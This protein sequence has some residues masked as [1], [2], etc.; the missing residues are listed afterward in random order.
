MWTTDVAQKLDEADTVTM[1]FFNYETENLL[2][3][4]LYL[5][6]KRHLNLCSLA[7]RF[8][9]RTISSHSRTSED[10]V[11]SGNLTTCHGKFHHHVRGYLPL[12][13]L[14]P[15][16]TH[17][18]P[19][20]DQGAAAKNP[21]NDPINTFPAFSTVLS[22]LKNQMVKKKHENQWQHAAPP[23]SQKEKPACDP[24]KPLCTA[25]ATV[26]P[27]RIFGFKS[28]KKKVM[29]TREKTFLAI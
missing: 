13:P 11:P 18:L 25:K 8:R 27:V 28:F 6:W 23:F 22:D 24:S 7:T 1:I 9:M 17:N 19:T 5:A 26:Q 3:K 15:H 12:A 20:F 2:V 29:I 21:S 4:M 16:P 10:Q 14:R